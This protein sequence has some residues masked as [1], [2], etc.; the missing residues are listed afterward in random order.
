VCCVCGVGS[1]CIGACVCARFRVDFT[2]YFHF[3]ATNG[4][5]RGGRRGGVGGVKEVATSLL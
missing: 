4:R 5:G 1:A 3:I 2:L